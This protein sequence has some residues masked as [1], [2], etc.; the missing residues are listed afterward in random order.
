MR[1]GGGIGDGCLFVAGMDSRDC[2]CCFCELEDR[3]VAD[4]G[5]KPW[6]RLS[7]AIADLLSS[8]LQS[9]NANPTLPTA[10]GFS[11][12]LLIIIRWF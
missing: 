5:G 6:K 12:F 8:A 7:S 9:A 11:F 3:G 1:A 10:N 4:G 2:C